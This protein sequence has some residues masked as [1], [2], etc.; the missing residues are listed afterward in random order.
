MVFQNY[1]HQ[2]LRTYKMENLF[3]WLSKETTIKSS[4]NANPWAGLASYGDPE[5]DAMSLTFYGREDESYDVAKLISNNIIVTLYGKSGIGKTSLL[6]AGVF[7]ELRFNNFTP[8]NIRLGIRESSINAISLQTKIISSI[9]NLVNNIEEI[10]VVEPQLDNQSLD[11]LWNWFARHR[12]FNINGIEVIPVLVFDQ[13][14][15]LFNLYRDEVDILLRQLDYINDRDHILDDYEFN[16]SNYRYGTNYRFVLS[17]REDDL[18]KLEDSIDNC[19]LPAL[20]RCRYRLHGLSNKGAKDVILKP[21]K[22]K[23]IFA[24]DDEDLIADKIIDICGGRDKNINTLMLSLLC[25]VL[26]ND[27]IV[28]NKKIQL[29]DLDDYKNVIQIYYLS[30]IENIPEKQ[31]KYLEDNLVDDQGRRR[32]IYLTDLRKYAPEA[33]SFIQSSS[34][35]LLNVSDGRVELVHDQLAAIMQSYR[36]QRFKDQRIRS[37]AVSLFSYYIIAAYFI[38]HILL[39]ILHASWAYMSSRSTLDYVLEIVKEISVDMMPMWN[40]R[41]LIYSQIFSCLLLIFLI[42]YELPRIVC[43]YFYS[44]LNIRKIVGVI[45]GVIVSALLGNNWIIFQS[46]TFNSMSFVISGWG[47]LCFIFIFSNYKNRNYEEKK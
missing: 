28:Q 10:N 45:S 22:E 34:A 37:I 47:I 9:E 5:T 3:H 8:I 4:Q 14:E 1:F 26:Y 43:E 35:R 32:S 36:N 29:A 33:E 13:F 38:W 11:F 25:Y 31:K 16:G 21:D 20:K 39:A 12:F 41:I 17:I 42:G 6:N 19:F 30:L 46:V 18:Y 7:P 2:L 27:S 44:N 23:N 15:E 24:K 40:V